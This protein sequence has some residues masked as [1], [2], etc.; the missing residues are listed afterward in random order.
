MYEHR[1]KPLA[2]RRKFLGRLALNAALASLIV[3][4]SLA[5]GV[6]GYRGFERLS[7]IDALLNASMILGAMGPVD[8]V[9][10]FGGKLFASFYALYSGL[11]F[12]VVA[13]IVFAP[14]LHRMLHTFHVE[15]D[16]GL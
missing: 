11:V 5:I 4:G 14:A 6:L 10:T 13:G 1:S 12:V 7:W 16:G 2:S 3:L 8:P 9:R 15:H